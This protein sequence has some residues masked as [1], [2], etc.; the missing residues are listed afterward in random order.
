[1]DTFFSILGILLIG[2]SLLAL[3][4]ALRFAR[5]ALRPHPPRQTRYQPKAV[6]I[7]PCR[8]V[9]HDFEEN[10]HAILTQDYRDYEVVFVTESQN[11]PAH[12]TL[13][14][15][16]NQSRRSTPPAWMVV[17]GE[18]RNQGQKVHN[19]CA[20]IDTLNSIDRRVQ[21][22]VFAD[23]DARPGR[24]W[25]ANLVAPLDDKQIGATTGYRWYAPSTGKQ[26]LSQTLASILLSLWN[27]SALALLG[28]RSGFA[29]GGSTAIRRENFDKIAVKKRW[30]GAASDDYVLTSAIHDHGQR[31]KFVPQCL[32]ASHPEATFKSLLEFTTRQMRITR[33]YS[34]GVWRLACVTHSLYNLTFWGGL[35]WLIASLLAGTPNHTLAALLAGVFLLGAV[36]NVTRA[37]VASHLLAGEGENTSKLWWAYSLLGPV[38]SLIYFYNIIASAWSRRITWRGISY[39]LISPSETVILH[40]PTQRASAGKPFRSSRQG[41]PSASS[42]SQKR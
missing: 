36:T 6:V 25:L 4:A 17:A 42:S 40:R 29:W 33:V 16:L 32:V 12:I 26:N 21:A 23:S 10:I 11:D 2:Q 7:V 5:Y 35:A 1:M 3:I 31:I 38:V 34:P 41:S 22:L 8:G 19:L 37:A 14:R 20:A 30:N 9:E 15:L 28:E 13:S 24:N 18:A 39:D 27:A